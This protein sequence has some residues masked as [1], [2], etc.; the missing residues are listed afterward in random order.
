MTGESP[1]QKKVSAMG[2]SN[3][4]R[5]V[6]WDDVVNDGDEIRGGHDQI[7]V[8]VA[9]GNVNS[10]RVRLDFKAD[11]ARP[12]STPSCLSVMSFI[13]LWQALRTCAVISSAQ[14]QR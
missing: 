13:L 7:G 3:V 10:G 11:S 9:K 4:V 5:N 14:P 8:A 2:R 6:K 12:S 1:R